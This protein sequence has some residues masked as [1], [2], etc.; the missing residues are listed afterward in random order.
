M[1]AGPVLLTKQGAFD[2]DSMNA[3]NNYFT[4]IQVTSI[5]SNAPESYNTANFV[6]LTVNGAVPIGPPLVPAIFQINKAGVLADT[7]A[8]PVAGATNDDGKIIWIVSNTANAHTVTATG[9]YQSGS[10]AVNLA[11]FAAFAG[12]GMQ[13]MALN[14][15]WVV[16][17]SV[18]VTFT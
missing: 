1:P 14:A 3:V 15:K 12:A 7:L 17:T 9:L 13:L 10:A 5:G 18:G 6:S 4:G 11:T 8:A 2:A 16:V